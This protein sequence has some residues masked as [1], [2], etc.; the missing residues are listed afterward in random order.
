MDQGVGLA[1]LAPGSVGARLCNLVAQGREL[2]KKE[3]NREVENDFMKFLTSEQ[4]Q[5]L[6]SP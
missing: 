4:C 1:K 3:F 6:L 5:E 2:P